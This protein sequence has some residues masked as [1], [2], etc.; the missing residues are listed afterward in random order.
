MKPALERNSELSSYFYFGVS[1]LIVFLMVCSE[2]AAAA[3]KNE[4]N[5][6][7]DASAVIEGIKSGR[8]NVQ[9]SNKIFRYGNKKLEIQAACHCHLDL[10]HRALF[11]GYWEIL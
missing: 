4:T 5:K 11:P 7:E 3:R 8:R 9:K 2:A 1:Q 10:N 6:Q